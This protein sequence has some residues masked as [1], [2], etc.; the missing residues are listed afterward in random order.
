MRDEKRENDG[1]L[2]EAEHLNGPPAAPAVYS[3]A[4]VTEVQNAPPTRED[5]LRLQRSMVDVACDM[6]QPRHHFAPGVYLRY[7]TVPA[8][9]LIVGKTHRHAHPMMVLSG[10]AVVL[11]EE[12][13]VDVG[14]GYSYVS[15]PGA[16]RV[17]LALE[18]TEFLT[19]HQNPDDGQDLTVIEAYVIDSEADML[20]FGKPQ[21]AKEIK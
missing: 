12:G 8:G 17:V 1:K 10:R 11:S 6:P 15:K 9:M 7:L 16:K 3:E 5:I 13:R 21:N 2:L 18:N 20:S 19:I 14:A 4:E